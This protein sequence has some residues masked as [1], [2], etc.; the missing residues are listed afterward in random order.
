MGIKALLLTTITIVGQPTS[1]ETTS[2]VLQ[3][4]SLC[5]NAMNQIV[6]HHG[7]KNHVF[8]KGPTH[9]KGRDGNIVLHV[10]CKELGA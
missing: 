9:M 10:T 4:K 2:N 6:E 7:M 1:V 5:G 8:S 3:D